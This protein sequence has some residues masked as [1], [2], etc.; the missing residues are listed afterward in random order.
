MNLGMKSIYE[1][2]TSST[3]WEMR[4]TSSIVLVFTSSIFTSSKGWEIRFSNCSALFF[5]L[6]EVLNNTPRVQKKYEKKIKRLL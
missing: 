5:L 2:T 6:S 3:G 1:S 4:F